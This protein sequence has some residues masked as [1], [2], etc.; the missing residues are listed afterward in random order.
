MS[1]NIIFYVGNVIC[2]DLEI[3]TKK[4]KHEGKE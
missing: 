1:H 3:V 2:S 4:S